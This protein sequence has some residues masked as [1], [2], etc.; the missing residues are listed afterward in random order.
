[1]VPREVV[2]F[3]FPRV[4]RENELLPK[5]VWSRWLDIGQVLFCL[6]MDPDEV[7]GSINSPKGTRPIFSHFD[8]KAWSIKDLL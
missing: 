2:R 4:L 5:L 3:V 7:E 1:M 8:G 6:F